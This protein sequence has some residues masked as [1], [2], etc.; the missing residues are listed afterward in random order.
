M[1]TIAIATVLV[2]GFAGTAAADMLFLEDGRIVDGKKLTKTD[3]GVKVGFE[4]GEVFVPK[5]LIR[6]I[7]VEGQSDYVP[8]TAKEKEQL[9]KG[10]VP[11][12]GRWMKPAKRERA[13]KK[14]LE[15]RRA[16]FEKVKAMRE[17]MNRHEEQTKHFSFEATV[18]PH[19]FERYRDMMEAYY[20][21][22]AK[23]FK[24]GQPG[25]LGKLS[26]CFYADL[27]YFL[28]NSG[29]PG[30][31]RGYFQFVKPLSL[32]FYYDRLDPDYSSEVLFHEANHY[33]Q[34][35]L[36]PAF[37]M[38]HFPSEAPERRCCQPSRR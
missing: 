2:L 19:I 16:Y 20:D 4:N 24:V 1:R 11:F 15:E 36:D 3:K 17:W 35:L 27:K 23:T 21:D 6:E 5:G 32:H 10:L 7:I 26:V 8:K 33:M 13:V 9:E 34:F 37:V 14:Y 29:A 12:Q 31:A 25:D 18:P 22:F 28:R 38:P 30:R